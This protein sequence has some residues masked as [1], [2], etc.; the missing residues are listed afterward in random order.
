[1]PPKRTEVEVDARE[2]ISLARVRRQKHR[3]YLVEE[4]DDG[5]LILT[6]AA[7]VPARLHPRTP[8]RQTPIEI[9]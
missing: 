2:R 4:Q 8:P 7:L 9:P 5:T 3:Y 6:P 1:M